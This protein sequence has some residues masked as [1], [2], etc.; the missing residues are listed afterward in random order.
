MFVQVKHKQWKDAMTTVCLEVPLSGREASVVL[1]VEL[2]MG[3]VL[4]PRSSCIQA[5]YGCTRFSKKEKA[6]AF[7]FWFLAKFAI[8]SRISFHFEE[9]NPAPLPMQ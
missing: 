5:A 1:D 3:T 9:Y 2:S 7:R 6:T 8:H 4:Y